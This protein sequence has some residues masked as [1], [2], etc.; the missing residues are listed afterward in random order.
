VTSA[1]A[2]AVHGA[3]GQISFLVSPV[4]LNAFIFSKENAS[5]A[6]PTSLHVEYR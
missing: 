2:G 3:D 4:D 6:Q 5:G 1:V